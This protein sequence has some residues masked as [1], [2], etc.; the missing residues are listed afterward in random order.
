MATVG[1][2]HPGEMGAAV[3]AVARA[4]VLWAPEARSEATAERARA[5]GLKAASLAEL[6]EG[7]DALLSICPPHAALDVARSV[8][9]FRGIYCDANA[10]AP[11]TARE[12]AGIVEAGGATAV[13]G[14]IVGGPPREPGTRL[15]VSGAAA[16][17]VGALFEGTALEPVTLPGEIGAAS[18]LKMC[19][20]AWTKGSAA[21]LLAAA[22]AAEAL[23]VEDAL[24]AE[25]ERSIPEL[26]ARLERAR[27]SA[28]SKGWRWVGEMREIEATLRAVDLPGG[29]HAA[30]AEVFDRR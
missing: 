16:G 24:H 12:V 7:C 11:A 22:A 28:D 13:D 18:A 14:G 15:Y 23:G 17:E 9:G 4:E 27:R 29:F 10:I 25:W 1:V 3:G 26:H 5:A 20:A 2:L 6:V 8:G 19:Y 30:A 21:L